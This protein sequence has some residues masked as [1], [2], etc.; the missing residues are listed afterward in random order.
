MH[1]FLENTFSELRFP[2]A[3][4]SDHKRGVFDEK[5]GLDE[6][7]GSERLDGLYGEVAHHGAGVVF[8]GNEAV[9][10]FGEF[11]GSAV[12]GDF[13]VVIE[14]GSLGGEFDLRLPGGFPPVAE[15]FS[16]ILPVFFRQTT[17]DAPHGRVN[18]YVF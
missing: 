18:E 13:Y 1:D 6:F 10:P 4:V 7:A 3:G 2:A 9:G 15:F 11:A 8:G 14:D 16:E 17:A 5:E 12:G